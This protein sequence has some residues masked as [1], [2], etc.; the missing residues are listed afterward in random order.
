APG[1]NFHEMN[2]K[3]VQTTYWSC[4]TFP[5]ETHCGWHQPILDAGA[6]RIGCEGS[7][8]AALR[9]GVVAGV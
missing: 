8:R 7:G 5:L 1:A 3:Y 9:A 2:A 4:V 6:G